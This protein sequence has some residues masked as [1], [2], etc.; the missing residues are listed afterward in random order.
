MGPQERRLSLRAR[1]DLVEKGARMCFP[2]E[3]TEVFLYPFASSSFLVRVLQESPPPVTSLPPPP[4][5]LSWAYTLL[6][7]MGPLG[8]EG[9]RYNLLRQTFSCNRSLWNGLLCTRDI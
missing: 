6:L 8:L 1:Q 4:P 5:S 9:E 2:A 7:E 3:N